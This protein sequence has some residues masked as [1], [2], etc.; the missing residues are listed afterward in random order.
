M[1]LPPNCPLM[2]GRVR[3]I[4]SMSIQLDEMVQC[5]C[6]INNDPV[7]LAESSSTDQVKDDGETSSTSGFSGGASSEATGEIRRNRSPPFL[8]RKQR[9]RPQVTLRYMQCLDGS[10]MVPETKG[11]P[12]VS[13]H[14]NPANDENIVNFVARYHKENM[15]V[16][17]S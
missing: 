17:I 15:I 4:S 8:A 6:S 10:L 14:Q 7:S 13:L 5:A 9:P 3:P 2:G 1:P 12:D 16:F 11:L